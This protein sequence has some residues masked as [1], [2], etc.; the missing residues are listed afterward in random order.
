MGLLT[1]SKERSGE[2]NPQGAL[3]GLHLYNL[4]ARREGLWMK[5]KRSNR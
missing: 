2:R 4:S 5:N 3:Q 1:Y